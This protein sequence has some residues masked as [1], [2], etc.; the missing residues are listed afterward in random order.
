MKSV[1]TI[2]FVAIVL[3]L[4]VIAGCGPTAKMALNMSPESETIYKVVTESGKDY[5]FTQPSLNKSKV[6]NTGSRT[7]ITFAQ[8]VTDVDVNGNA[9][10]DITIK[11]IKT[12]SQ[13][14]KG[15]NYEFDSISEKAKADDLFALIGATYKISIAKNGEVKTLDASAARKAV[16]K[17]MARKVASKLLSDAE[18]KSRHQILAFIDADKGQCK[19]GQ[20]WSSLAASPPGM[21]KAKSFEKIYTVESMTEKGDDTIAMI[22][23]NAVPSSKRAPG[24][25]DESAGMG[26][27]ANMFD[28]S[29]EFTG[30]M[31]INLTAGEIMSYNEDLQA[32]WVA[33]EPSADVDSDKGPDQLTMGFTHLFSIEK[34]Q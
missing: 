12:I 32:Q 14:Q 9:T 16:K 28:E 4:I 5:E 26:L 6:Q 18:I 20:S 3:S 11:S 7:E 19:V 21:L 24:A 30:T 29:N 15:V 13:S 34:I 8:K 23:M 10:A 2:S 25:K 1:K 22:K 33:V 31:L 27:F 17:G